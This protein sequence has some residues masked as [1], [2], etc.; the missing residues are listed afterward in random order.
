[1]PSAEQYFARLRD[2]RYLLAKP[3]ASPEE[4][5]GLMIQFG[6]LLQGLQLAPGHAVLDFGAGSITTTC[7]WS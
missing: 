1:M 5:P 4:A 3:F 7:G 6:Q 2:T